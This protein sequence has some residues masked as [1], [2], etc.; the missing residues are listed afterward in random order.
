MSIKRR[1]HTSKFKFRV[2]LEAAQNYKTVNQIA[3][4]HNV[5]TNLVG[6]WRKQLMEKGPDIFLTA[7][8]R[9]AATRK[10]KERAMQE[11]S[12]YEQIGRLR[13]ENEWLKKKYA[14]FT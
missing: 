7:S 1:N 8:A 10:K 14:Q 5:H 2:A 12:L 13:M 6:T 9:S 3:G 11:A 4:R